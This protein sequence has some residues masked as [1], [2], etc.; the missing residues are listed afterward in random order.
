VGHTILAGI[1][2]GIIPALSAWWL[3]QRIAARVA[4]P[5]RDTAGVKRTDLEAAMQRPESELPSLGAAL[6]PVLLPLGLIGAVSM[7][8]VLN[9]KF[10]W[11]SFLGERHVALTLG[12]LAAMALVMKQRR[13]GIVEVNKLI[14]PQFSTAGVIILVSCAG[15]AF[16]AMLKHAGVAAVVEAIAVRWDLNLIFLAWLISAVIRVAQGS[17]TVAMMTASAIMYPIISAAPQP[18]HPMYIFLAIGFGSKMVSWM[19]D[20]GF[21]TVSKISG[22]TESETLRSWTILVT[23]GSLIGLLQCLIFS[24]ILPFAM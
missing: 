13:V 7:M 14:G 11:L 22:F 16:G 10:E 8:S 20:S 1:A 2:A 4:A 12:A 3:A 19:N 15:G 5:L 6:L 21:W 18:F 9:V 23:V 17:A 24:R